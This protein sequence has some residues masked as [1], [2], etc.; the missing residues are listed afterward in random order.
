[1]AAAT[2][3]LVSDYGYS[4]HRRTVRGISGFTANR[5]NRPSEPF[6]QTTPAT[7]LENRVNG[8]LRSVTVLDDTG[9]AVVRLTGESARY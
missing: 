2:Q 5:R 1:M 8:A 6:V 9:R 7:I 4:A 3:T